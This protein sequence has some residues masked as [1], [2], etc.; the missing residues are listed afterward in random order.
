ME[1]N[2]LVSLG[3][4][5]ENPAVIDIEYTERKEELTPGCED[6]SDVTEVSIIGSPMAARSSRKMQHSS[7]NIQSIPSETL[8]VEL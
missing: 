8:P 3:S 1:S 6:Q 2:D 7:M 4:K 5:A